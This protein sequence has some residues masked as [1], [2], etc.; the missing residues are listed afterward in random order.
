MTPLHLAAQNGYDDIVANL[1][2]AG[3]EINVEDNNGS[4]PLNRY[5]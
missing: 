3:A 1:I 2:S 4:T 5:E